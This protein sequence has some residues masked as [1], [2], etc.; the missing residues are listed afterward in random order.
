MTTTLPLPSFL[1]VGDGVLIK[2]LRVW[3]LTR[4]YEEK[5]RNLIEFQKAFIDF[6]HNIS[7]HIITFHEPFPN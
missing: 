5:T 2:G 3:P 4:H 6:S 1:E 7:V